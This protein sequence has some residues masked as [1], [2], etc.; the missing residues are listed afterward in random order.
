MMMPLLMCTQSL[1]SVTDW[2]QGK[3]KKSHGQTSIT[4]HSTYLRE[5]RLSQTRMHIFTFD[6]ILNSSQHTASEIFFLEIFEFSK[7][8][9]LV[10]EYTHNYQHH[11][12]IIKL[13]DFW[14]E[15]CSMSTALPLVSLTGTWW[16]I[17]C[18]L[19][20]LMYFVIGTD[21]GV[22]LQLKSQQSWN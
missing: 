12:K 16:I 7:L 13:L 3:K 10:I 8:H 6:C 2:N 1:L 15:I 5:I 9:Q 11:L 21:P 17:K 18:S 19:M 14:I 4:E 20:L 22:P